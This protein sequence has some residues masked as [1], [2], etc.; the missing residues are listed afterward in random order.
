MKKKSKKITW[1]D[2]EAFRRLLWEKPRIPIAHELY[3]HPKTLQKKSRLSGCKVQLVFCRPT[4]AASQSVVGPAECRLRAEERT[5]CVTTMD[6][7]GERMLV[8]DKFSAVRVNHGTGYPCG[9]GF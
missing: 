6:C 2:Y 8:F 9:F 7:G 5:E 3:C 4:P 1:P